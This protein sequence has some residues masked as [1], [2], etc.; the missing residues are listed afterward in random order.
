MP[1]YEKLGKK[2]LQKELETLALSGVEFSTN[3]SSKDNETVIEG[4]TE[5]EVSTHSEVSSSS[6]PSYYAGDVEDED[7]PYDGKYVAL[8]FKNVIEFLCFFDPHIN[9]GIVRPY[10][11]Q[12]QIGN[13]LSGAQATSKQP[14]KVAVCACNGS[15]KDAYVIAPWAVFFCACKIK[16]RCIIT[17]SSGVQLSSQ[18]EG[19]IR[20]LATKVNEYFLNHFGGPVFK[21]NQRF[22][23]CI[24]SGSEIRLF[25]TDEEG[26]AEG[27]HPIEPNAEMCII[28]NE[29]KSVSPEIYRA[30]RRCT[31]YNY[32]LDVS[33]PGEPTGDFHRHFTNWRHKY[34]IDYT[35]CEHHSDEERLEDLSQ[36]GSENG[37]YRSK[38]MALFTS[39]DSNAVIPF[40]I[41]ER[42][43]ALSKLKAIAFVS[44]QDKWRI[45]IDLAGGGAENAIVATKGN[46]IVRDKYFK[47]KD[48]MLAATIIN[49]FLSVELSISPSAAD[50]YD[51]YIDD[52]G[53]GR[54]TTDNLMNQGWTLS[55]IRNQSAASDKKA[56]LNLGAQNWFRCKRIL[57]ENLF[58][59]DRDNDKLYEQL[60]NRYYKQQGTQGRIALEAKADAIA[61]GRPSPDRADAF[62]LALTGLTVDDFLYAEKAVAEKKSN[63]IGLHEVEAFLA[64]QQNETEQKLKLK[65]KSHG[66]VSIVLDALARR[67]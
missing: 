5:K 55:R 28:V 41:V 54:G 62:V 59:L 50:T 15:G 24:I 2:D 27:Y 38:W 65:R 6:A 61:H 52:N 21:I 9:A 63:R 16:S 67:N 13:D 34:H 23:K 19:Y 51:I 1:L 43:K 35:K 44:L 18:T 66:S 4:S 20:N 58:I 39:L 3:I 14:F 40:E 56:F 53:I 25:A 11:W 29:A 42:V 37:Y 12:K 10:D 36:Y 33:S 30:L 46:R 22:I 26:K 45:G 57:E 60:S 48:T 47:E 64:S 17:S 31:G 32:W 7:K 8:D 49:H